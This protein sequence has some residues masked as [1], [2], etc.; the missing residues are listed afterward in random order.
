MKREDFVFNGSGDV[1]LHGCVWMPE[2]EVRAVL[3]ITHGMTEHIGRYEKLAEKLTEKGIAVCGFDLRGHGLNESQMNIATMGKDGWEASLN[4]MHRI[5]SLFHGRYPDAP[6]FMLGFSL[7]SFLLREYISRHPKEMKGAI[8]AGTGCQPAF[9]LEIMKF[10]VSTQIAKNGF[11]DTT[12][13]VRKLSFDTYNDKFKPCRTRFDWLCSDEAQLDEYM[14]DDAC[15]RDISSG[16][17]HQLLSSM[18]RTGQQHACVGWNK[19]MPVLLMSGK[20]DP[21][22][23]MGKGVVQ[24]LHNM[25][26]RGFKDVKLCLYEKARHDIFHE[27]ENGTADK[28]TEEIAR[29][30]GDKI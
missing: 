12:D 4:D 21:V 3:Q 11:D 9:V 19:E 25:E 8:I 29:W 22:G 17:F 20:D 10:I 23:N 28:V 26:K 7:G 30:I 24:I 27:Y 15:R 1:R 5:Y 14:N 6:Y 16:L 2:N 18:K 13:L